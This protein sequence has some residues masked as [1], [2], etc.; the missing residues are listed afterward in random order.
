M[1]EA[2]AGGLVHRGEHT[3]KQAETRPERGGGRDAEPELWGGREEAA[4]TTR[5]VRCKDACWARK[6]FL[7]GDESESPNSA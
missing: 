6:A 3:L 2:Q 7:K 1:R 4:L 5:L